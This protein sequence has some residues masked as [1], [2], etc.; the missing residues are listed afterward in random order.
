MTH[1][2]IRVVKHLVETAREIAKLEPG[3]A[4]DNLIAFEL[5]MRR[6]RPSGA[7]FEINDR[8]FDRCLRQAWVEF[9]S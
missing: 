7:A 9:R 1:A 6:H 5:V 2:E 4:C 8:Q 3:W